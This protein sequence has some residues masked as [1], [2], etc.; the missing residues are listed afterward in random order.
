[1]KNL[2]VFAMLAAALTIFN[3]CQKDDLIIPEK[4]DVQSSYAVTGIEEDLVFSKTI[5]VLG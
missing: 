4:E 5:A 1:M 3:G 2:I